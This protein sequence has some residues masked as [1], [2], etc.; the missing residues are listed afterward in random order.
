MNQDKA[1]PLFICDQ[2]LDQTGR[3]SSIG[4]VHTTTVRLEKKLLVE[5]YF[6]DPTKER[7][8]R[9]KRLIRIT[10]LGKTALVKSRDTKLKL[11][12]QIPDLMPTNS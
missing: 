2:I 10:S 7:G 3:K 9:R 8:G 11:W 6:G 1:Y 12:N 5:S 4:A